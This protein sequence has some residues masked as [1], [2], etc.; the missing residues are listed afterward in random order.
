MLWIQGRIEDDRIASD[1]GGGEVARITSGSPLLPNS[2]CRAAPELIGLV[3][4]FAAS[5]VQHAQ[6]VM[7][8]SRLN[9]VRSTNRESW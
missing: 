5:V 7:V 9:T 4:L 1:C 3:V 8:D 6:S 2:K